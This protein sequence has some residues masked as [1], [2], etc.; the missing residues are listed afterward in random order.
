MVEIGQNWPKMAKMV[1][2]GNFWQQVVY[3]GW[4]R[5]RYRNGLS[6]P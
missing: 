3:F 2:F 5:I 1:T 6:G 4:F